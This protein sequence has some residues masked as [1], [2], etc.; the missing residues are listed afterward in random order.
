MIV[1]W[2][3]KLPHNRTELRMPVGAAVRAVQ[4]QN[5]Y[6]Y[7]WAEVDPGE[8]HEDRVFEIYKTGVAIPEDPRKIYISTFQMTGARYVG[9]VYDVTHVGSEPYYD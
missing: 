9:H 1:I 7:M 3:Y 8:P 2:E 5:G 6:V 4:E